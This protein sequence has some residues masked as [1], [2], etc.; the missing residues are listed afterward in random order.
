MTSLTNNEYF[1]R[2]LAS[3]VQPVDQNSANKKQH[4]G[5]FW[6]EPPSSTSASCAPGMAAGSKHRNSPNKEVNKLASPVGTFLYMNV[7]S[8]PSTARRASHT[9]LLNVQLPPLSTQKRRGLVP[10]II[11][12]VLPLIISING[13]SGHP[14]LEERPLTLCVPTITKRVENGGTR[15]GD[16]M[17]GAMTLSDAIDATP[18]MPPCHDRRASCLSTRSDDSTQNHPRPRRW[19]RVASMA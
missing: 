19:T 14:R 16:G 3:D 5:C 1:A 4:S 17:E 7:V 8:R 11:F 13:P 6:R 9:M 2:P 10:T 12:F 15:R 18:A